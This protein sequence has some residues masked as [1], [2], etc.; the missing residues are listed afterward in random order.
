M[1]RNLEKNERK[2][3]KQ[4]NVMIQ[5]TWYKFKQWKR[6]QE[7]DGIESKNEYKNKLH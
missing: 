2:Y 4:N 3:N 1:Y 6:K 5:K 7:P